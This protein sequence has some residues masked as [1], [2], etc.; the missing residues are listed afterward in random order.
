MSKP[1]EYSTM[2][3]DRLMLYTF[4]ALLAITIVTGALWSQVTTPSGWNLGVTVG[5]CALIAVGIAVGVDALLFKVASDSPLNTASA[6][7]FGLIVTL[8]YSLGVPSMMVTEVAPLEAPAC[9][10][11][12]ALITLIGMVL[13]KKLQGLAGRKF[14][15]PAA[16]AKLLVLLPLLFVVLIPADHVTD[17]PT[18]AT[19]L[20]YS[21]ETSFGAFMQYCFT[22]PMPI[23]AGNFPAINQNAVLQTLFLEKY[24]GWV[25][26][27]S[28]L[29]V[30]IAGIALFA[31]ARR[32]IKWRI[33]LSYIVTTVVFAGILSAVYGG[34]PV[35]RI[36]FHL[37]VGS[38]IFLA[39]FMATD[40]ATTPLTYMG[41]AIFGAGVAVLT[42]LLQ[43][44]A[45]FFGGSILALIIMNL[46]VPKLD[47]IGKLKPVEGGEEP[48]LPKGKVFESIKTTACIRCG[49]CMRI[50][51]NKL[52]PILIKQARDKNNMKELMSLDADFCAG[53]GSCNYVCPA[54]IDLKSN[55]LNFPL[56]EADEQTI[57]QT[58]LSGSMEE[59][60]GVYKEMFSAKGKYSGQ[61]GGVVTALLASGM[62]KGMFDAAIVVK[63]S[64]GYLAES[65][66]A[67]SVDD[68]VKAA[69]TKYVRVRIMSK[70]G[71]LIAKGKRKIA[72]VGTPCE[73]RAAR[74]I[75][76]AMLSDCPDLEL[77][78]IGLF[79]YEDFNYPILKSEIQRLLNVDLDK[80][81][82]TQIKKGKFIVTVDGKESSVPVK[83]L[84]AAVE[85]GC[86]SCPDFASKYADISV[87]SVGSEDG[88][89]TVIVR[90]DVG[91]KLLEGLDLE[92]TE[93]KKEEVIKLAV[94]KKKR[95]EQNA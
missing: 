64:K 31:V 83:D 22:N 52:S 33:T 24:H 66:V 82:K 2:T 94:N 27:A 65:Y 12:V 63:R 23:A 3:K 29:A 30:I 86:L 70:L 54:R 69:G 8:S 84:S 40:P 44:Y 1:K 85:N 25:G 74:R 4:I 20:G 93:V 92:K 21:G 89:S 35:L 51:C 72:I 73:I 81:E 45:H 17:I 7:V 5:V 48:K 10:S 6:A 18:L 42:I 41:Q 67:E 11:W 39:F 38:S 87:G 32:Y 91:A 58:F 59:N 53:C 49:A 36:A 62:E 43:T 13:F 46:T 88:R 60:L 37:F 61:D 9:F 50:C 90:S 75:Q 71:E 57:E 77:T 56:S 28:S 76:L 47:K 79:C 55:I 95:A 14:V 16:A 78:L 34:D 80:A 68:I 15:N 26:G 19:S